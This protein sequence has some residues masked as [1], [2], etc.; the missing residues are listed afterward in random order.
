MRAERDPYRTATALAVTVV[1]LIAAGVSYLHIARLALA[2]GQ[3]PV[4]AYLLPLSIDGV[5][6]TSSLVMLRSARAGIASPWLSQLGLVL[7]VGATLGANIASG[8]GHGWIG[9]LLSGWPAIGFVLSAETAISMS[10][11]RGRQR[12]V[13]PTGTTPARATARRNTA[14]RT[15]ISDASTKERAMA[16]L[17]RHPG[18]SGAELGRLLGASPRTGQRLL[19]SL[20][21]H[22]LTGG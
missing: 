7:S 18:L 12:S 13:A 14:T 2:Y 17:A 16:E 22:A 11:R 1:A 20:N 15:R 21:G 6:A 19:T 5:V 8:L 10:R 3:E 9:A 4:A